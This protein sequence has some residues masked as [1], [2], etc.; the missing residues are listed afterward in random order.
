MSRCVV[1]GCPSNIKYIRG[2]TNVTLHMF[3]KSKEKITLWLQQTGQ[4]FEDMKY[5]VQEIHIG[6]NSSY[7]M[8]S[9]HFTPECYRTHGVRRFLKG[10]AIPTI[11]PHS[12][13]RPEESVFCE[14]FTGAREKLPGT[15]SEDC[16]SVIQTH[17][18]HSRY[19]QVGAPSL[20]ATT[21][22]P[23]P[24]SPKR[25][26]SLVEVSSKKIMKDAS[27]K[28]YFNMVDCEMWTG[29]TVTRGFGK[30]SGEKEQS[31]SSSNTLTAK[32]IQS[33]SSNFP[34][35][36][37]TLSV[38]SQDSHN[39]LNTETK[40]MFESTTDEAVE[41]VECA[42]PRAYGLFETNSDTLSA[43]EG[44]DI[45][46]YDEGDDE[47]PEPMLPT[48]FEYPLASMRPERNINVNN[49]QEEESSVSSIPNPRNS[50]TSRKQ[51]I[52]H[53]EYFPHPD[54]ITLETS[55]IK[56][57]VVPKIEEEELNLRDHQMVKE[58]EIPVN[59]RKASNSLI[60]SK[61]KKKMTEKILNCSLEIIYLLTGEHL[62]STIKM[63]E[64]DRK[65]IV[66]ILNPALEIIYLLT[67]EVHI[68]CDD[69][70]IYFSMEEW[71]YIEGHKE[72]YKDVMMENHQTLRA[73]GIPIN[74]S[75]A[76][77]SLMIGKKMA[78]KI[79]TLALEIMSLL[80]GE[81][82][83]NSIKITEMKDKKIMERILGHTQE[84]IHLLTGEVPI[85]CGD[86]AVYFSL[87]EW[88][89]IEGHK[90]L[91]KDVMMENHQTLKTLEILG[92]RSSGSERVRSK[93]D[94]EEE[95]NVR[96]HQQIKEEEIAVTIGEDGSEI[97]NTL[98]EDH[99][100]PS[101]PDCVMEDMHA[102]HS[103]L[104]TKLKTCTGQNRFECSDCGKC[105]IWATT[106][107]QHMRTHTGEKPFACSDCGECFSWAAGLRLH[108]RTHTGEKPF[109]CSECGKCFNYAS[110]LNEHMRTHTGEK[111]FPCSECGK[112]F[113][114]APNL[115]E[116]MRTHTG[117]K[118]F[119]CSKC[120]KS[121]SRATNLHEHMRTHTGE[122][123]FTCSECGECFSWAAGFRLHMRTHT[124]GKPFACSECGKC[125][126]YASNLNE[127][128]RTHTGEKPFTCS[129]CGK[130]FIRARNLHE[131]M[132]THTGEKPFTCSECGK[133]FS[134]ATNLHEH[135]RTHTGK[136]TFACSERGKCFSQTTNLHEH[137]RTY[138]GKKAFTCSEC[139]KCFSRVTH[140]HGH[141][142]THTG[143]KPFAC[144]ECGKC[145]SQASNLQRHMR[146][147][148][149]EKPFACS[150]CGN[151][152][153]RATQLNR[154]M[155]THT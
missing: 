31:S 120:G 16:Q 83:T 50:P 10:D 146:T 58:E 24:P 143:E 3:P 5:L 55:D 17:I 155:R 77:E 44:G 93:P 37:T 97:W 71:E 62:S 12:Q 151:C 29:G 60:T 141:M 48:E 67:G 8:C 27:T 126:H 86:V 80:T 152:F 2:N 74:R 101:S 117:E 138:T 53:P 92:N 107:K 99:I 106:L 42:S 49:V 109:A 104:E 130:C 14:L 11:F 6:R 91:Y 116:H 18:S 13:T 76:S 52:K 41:E 112:C 46:S 140:L 61:D 134:R 15:L 149:G 98:E 19:S 137:K 147:H 33:N 43:S 127:H 70:A 85:K 94:Q 39:S 123:P 96:N 79:L 57:P 63:N 9:S 118:P 69:V 108:M 54:D 145:F 65:E 136:K 135:M 78:E 87:K 4:E 59:I 150:E 75:S 73:L 7:K 68:K 154:H 88:E 110:N 1:K 95:T 90:E 23:C 119:T 47:I 131:H 148:T 35:I 81:H 144:S 26:H 45:D 82:L 66:M 114:R 72:L 56:H 28:D 38:A 142:R 102:S 132:R 133:C 64:M 32:T 21:D 121:F 113:S 103:Y 122:K 124:G 115:N 84:I 125:F 128:M 36:T 111:P 139:G 25:P 20:T 51:I 22:V 34:G 153:S 129:E 30:F 89:Y 105:F 100:P 40:Q